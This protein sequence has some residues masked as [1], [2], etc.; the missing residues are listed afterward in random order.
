MATTRKTYTA[1]FKLQAVRVVTDQ[2]LAVAEVA[3]AMASPRAAST[4][5]STHSACGERTPFPGHGRLARTTM[6]RTASPPKSNGSRPNATTKKADS[7][8]HSTT[9]SRS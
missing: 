6:S 8:R 7:A 9:R 1:E 5:G 2:H 3:R 4:T